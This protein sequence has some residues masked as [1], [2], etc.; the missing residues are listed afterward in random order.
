MGEAFTPIPII[1]LTDTGRLLCSLTPRFTD[2][3]LQARCV[4]L[5]PQLTDHFAIS[6]AAAA[7]AGD[8]VCFFA[9]LA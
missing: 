9:L 8:D 3:L 7:A 5:T 6:R 1:P 2:L 4:L